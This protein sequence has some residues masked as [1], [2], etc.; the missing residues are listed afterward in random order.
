VWGRFDAP[1]ANQYNNFIEIESGVA[2]SS[3]L[4][5]IIDFDVSSA[6]SNI[7]FGYSSDSTASRKYIRFNAGLHTE[8]Y[9]GNGFYEQ[10][11]GAWTTFNAPTSNKMRWRS[12]DLASLQEI[13]ATAGTIT[14][15]IRSVMGGTWDSAS[16]MQL[17]GYR[18][19]VDATGD[20]RIKNGAPTSDTD[21]TV[22]GA[23]T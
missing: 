2:P 5:S 17:G 22:V 19:W 3:V 12:N 6:P 16:L 14:P 23:Q 20:L 15:K 9:E 1:I 8:R 18:L 21:G 13:D 4:A 11:D 7:V 10:N